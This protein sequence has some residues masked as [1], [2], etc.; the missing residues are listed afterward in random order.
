MYDG[1]LSLSFRGSQGDRGSRRG[2]TLPST[3]QSCAPSSPVAAPT[4]DSSQ[5]EVALPTET[6]HSA[7]DTPYSAPYDAAILSRP[8][9][10]TT[11]IAASTSYPLG[12]S[13]AALPAYPASLIDSGDSPIV[14]QTKE[15][16]E[17]QI[18]LAPADVASLE[19][20]I[21]PAMA[22]SS[23]PRPAPDASEA[24]APAPQA[25]PHAAPPSSR[26]RLSCEFALRGGVSAARRRWEQR[27]QGQPRD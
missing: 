21:S 2:H 27:G 10:V 13:E 6:K 8:V 16:A 11:S 7:P 4:V 5:I 22:S 18:I 3:T 17:T 25:L 26:R 24:A 20:E 23:S 9:V 1:L 12:E 15:P 19:A 14:C